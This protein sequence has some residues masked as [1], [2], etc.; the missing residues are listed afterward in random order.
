MEKFIVN[1]LDEKQY[2]ETFSIF[3]DRSHEYEQMLTFLSNNINKQQ[4]QV[5][6]LSVGAGTGL[7]D[8]QLISLLHIKPEYTAIEPNRI[9]A[10]KLIENIHD[11][12]IITDY[13]TLT[14]HTTERFDYILFTHSL[15]CFSDPCSILEYSINFLNSNGKIVAF[16]Q[17]EIGMCEFVNK[18]NQYFMF[19]NNVLANHTYSANDILTKLNKKLICEKYRL[20]CFVDMDRIFDNKEILHK[21]LSFFM[22]MDTN[23]LPDYIINIMIDDLRN[24]MI[25]QKYI[26]P[27]DVLV[28][29]R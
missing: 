27:T 10:D 12:N 9:H 28:I 3:M 2:A 16:H 5:K 7:F 13:F 24:N 20:D 25:D 23:K 17:S 1:P 4:K 19:M 22:Q 6:I 18:F 21:M 14:F 15:Y 26:H 11:I 8:K 29:S